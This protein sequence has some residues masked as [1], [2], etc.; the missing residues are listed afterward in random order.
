MCV[1]FGS[2]RTANSANGIHW[3]LAGLICVDDEG[4]RIRADY[5]MGFAHHASS[6]MEILRAGM[7]KLSCYNHLSCQ[8]WAHVG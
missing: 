7:C 8:N 2:G 3:E 6:E 5:E 4:G 1:S